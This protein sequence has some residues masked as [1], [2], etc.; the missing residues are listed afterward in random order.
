MCRSSVIVTCVTQTGNAHIDAISA[1]TDETSCYTDFSGEQSAFVAWQLPCGVFRP[2]NA[3][4]IRCN[5]DIRNLAV[6]ASIPGEADGRFRDRV[7]RSAGRV[8]AR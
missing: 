7:K 2:L 3:C 6:D 4:N 8:T 5:A 1:D